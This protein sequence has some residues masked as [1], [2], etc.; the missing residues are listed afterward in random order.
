MPSKVILEMIQGDSVGQRHVFDERTTCIIG[1]SKDCMVR[2]PN[3][4]EHLPI[5]RH[6]CL[7]DINPPDVR[8][9]DFGS[10]NGTFVNGQKIGQ[11]HKDQTPE[12]V[13]GQQFP[14]HDLQDGDEIRLRNT[15]FRVHIHPALRCAHC[16]AE[17]PDDQQGAGRGGTL[18][19]L[20]DTCKVKAKEE[21]QQSQS[22]RKTVPED[23]QLC[24]KCGRDIANE[25]GAN[26]QGEYICAACRS[27]PLELLRV[28]LRAATTGEENLMAI[29]GYEVIKELGRGGM[30]AVYLAQHKRTGQEVA[31]KVMLPQVA[32]S[33]LMARKFMR[34]IENTK[35]LRHPHVVRLHDSGCSRGTF[36]F[37]LD[38]CG[39]GSL[40]NLMERRGKTIRLAKA[41]PLIYQ[42]LDGLEYAHGVRVEVP[43]ED[44][45]IRTVEGLV[46][47]DLKPQNIFLSRG[48]EKY[49]AKVGDYGLAKAFDAAGLSG[50]TCTGTVAGTPHF[51]PR[52]Q[53]LQFKFAKPEVDIWAAAASLYYILT[54]YPPRDFGKGKDPWQVVLQ[55]KAVPIRERH[56]KIPERIADVIDEALIDDPEI[57]FKTA[58]EFKQALQE[59]AK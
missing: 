16:A 57:R 41:L 22:P 52:Q 15:V 20:C 42:V 43:L 33:D 29:E 35:A 32:A 44:G 11:R 4:R 18:V 10:L 48:E 23:V 5:S 58:A 38:Y 47:R 28:L 21:L 27:E 2:V 36:F 7:L 49:Q 39:G 40:D 30:G 17:I 13:A 53:V 26:R 12:E 59:A 45:S 56:A 25:T 34:E 8:V 37:T 31:L 50:Q 6:H 14:E 55:T 9:R 19:C 51:M 54:G 1:R 46:H 3:N 24:T